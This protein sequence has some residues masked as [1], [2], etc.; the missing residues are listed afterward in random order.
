MA[1]KWGTERRDSKKKSN[2]IV[3]NT[4]VQ[5]GIQHNIMVLW[6]MHLDFISDNLQLES[7]KSKMIQQQQFSRMISYTAIHSK[8][9]I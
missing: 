5:L 3:P 7:L 1:V 6:Y 8:H 4:A 9:R 2:I